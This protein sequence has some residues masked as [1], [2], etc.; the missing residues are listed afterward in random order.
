MVYPPFSWSFST[1][2][3]AVSTACFSFL[4]DEVETIKRSYETQLSMMSDHLCGMNEKLTSQQDEIEVLKSG[5]TKK[6][7]QR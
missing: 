7:K 3:F 5:K 6:G 2:Y 4:Q 1:K